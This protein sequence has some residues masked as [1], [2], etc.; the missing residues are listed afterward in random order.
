MNLGSAGSFLSPPI[1]HIS[2]RSHILLPMAV[3][4]HPGC[5]NVVSRNR[6]GTFSRYCGKTHGQ[7]VGKGQAKLK[8]AICKVTLVKMAVRIHN[9]NSLQQNCHIRP[10]YVENGRCM[11]IRSKNS[12]PQADLLTYS[13]PIL[14]NPLRRSLQKGQYATIIEATKWFTKAAKAS[15]YYQL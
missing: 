9:T 10:V 13:T 14:W 8:S 15:E 2:W 11:W 7:A 5:S 6:D 3:C 12:I 1:L 4:A